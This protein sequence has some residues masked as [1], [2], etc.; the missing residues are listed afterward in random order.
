VWQ[1]FRSGQF[2]QQELLL[3]SGKAG[4]A[5][6]N[7]FSVDLGKYLPPKPPALPAVYLIRVTPG[8]KPV[9]PGSSKTVYVP[10]K[11]VGPPSNDVVITYS[12]V[13][14]PG[15]EFK[16]FE[17]YQNM[18]F[19]LDSIHMIEDQTGG[20]AE[21]FHIAGFVQ[22]S[23]PAG[24]A[25]AGSQEKFGPYF[26]EID[27]DGLRT[28]WLSHWSSFSLNKPDSPEWPRAYTVV[29]SVMEEDDGGSLNEW[30]S[31]VWDV[32]QEMVNGDV[33]QDIRDFLQEEFKDFVGDNVD[34]IIQSGGQIAQTIASLIGSATS[35]IVG[36]IVAAAALVISDIISGM[37]DDYYGTEVFVFV[38]PTNITDFVE[39]LPGQAIAGGYQLETDNL[40]FQG[41]TSWPEAAAWDGMVEVLFHWE[42][43]GKYQS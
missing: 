21:E 2:G 22:E 23:L 33:N 16:I 11:A 1:L 42:F 5:P 34:Q 37:G 31:I 4:D 17:I 27:P 40:V 9:L 6:G 39:S 10:A 19:L 32:A 12:A 25:Q 43:S 24:S 28:K 36:M 26:R 30:E 20:G 18:T 14:T 38:L 13:V 3:A 35:A 15:V 8:T 7:I 41:Y 29:I